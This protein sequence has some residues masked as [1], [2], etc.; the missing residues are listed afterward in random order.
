MHR[1]ELV[2]RLHR[3]ICSFQWNLL[4]Q[5]LELARRMNRV[6]K[7]DANY[8]LKQNVYTEGAKEMLQHRIGKESYIIE[9]ISWANKVVNRQKRDVIEN[10]WCRRTLRF[11]TNVASFLLLP[12]KLL[13][14]GPQFPL[15][16]HRALPV[17]SKIWLLYT[18]KIPLYSS[19]E[20]EWMFNIT[21]D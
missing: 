17:Y 12:P 4:Q 5:S 16:Q 2:W 8:V 20:I 13:K 1:R 9:Y 14:R 6:I 10:T 11:Q 3:R 15:R 21:M 7:E 18:K 19:F